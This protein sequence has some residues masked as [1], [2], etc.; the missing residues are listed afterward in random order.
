MMVDD[1]NLMDKFVQQNPIVSQ[2]H[3]NSPST[4]SSETNEILIR[5]TSVSLKVKFISK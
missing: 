1:T 4:H 5:P 2:I 3:V